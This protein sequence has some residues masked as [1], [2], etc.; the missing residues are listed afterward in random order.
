MSVAELCDLPESAKNPFHHREIIP[1][2]MEAGHDDGVGSPFM[3]KFGA[4]FP[5]GG[6]VGI[7]PTEIGK[8][9]PPGNKAGIAYP[10]F[11]I[12]AWRSGD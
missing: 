8:I 2:K 5:F 4:G 9:E 12:H 3:K 7:R 11:V 10:F 1:A 6:E